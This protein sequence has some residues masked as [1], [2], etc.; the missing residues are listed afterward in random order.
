MRKTLL[1]LPTGLFAAR[2][3]DAWLLTVLPI[4]SAAPGAHGRTKPVPGDDWYQR[5]SS[6]P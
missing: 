1:G 5:R 3:A 6:L 4:N 2:P